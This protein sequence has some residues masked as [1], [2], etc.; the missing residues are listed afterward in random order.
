MGKR[1]WILIGVIVLLSVGC[2]VGYELSP[3][4]VRAGSVT[5]CSDPKHIGDRAISSDVKTVSVARCYAGRYQVIQKQATCEACRKRIAEEERKAA[6]AAERARREEARRARA[7]ELASK[8]GGGIGWCGV[9]QGEPGSFHVD[10]AE[11]SI[12]P[13]GRLDFVVVIRNFSPEPISGLKVRIT[14]GDAITDDYLNNLTG[15]TDTDALKTKAREC[16]SLFADGLELG[17]LNPF[18]SPYYPHKQFLWEGNICSYGNRAPRLKT[19][20]QPG[21]DV[22]LH[23]VVDVDGSEVDLNTVVVHV[24][25][26]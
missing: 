22:R 17:T 26:T 15:C 20:A 16:R 6:E 21:T 19:S 24:M 10:N 3:V 18:N 12:P 9:W 2:V 25:H 1:T 13:G 8:I 23:V 11:V 4:P 14:S 5:T 7:R